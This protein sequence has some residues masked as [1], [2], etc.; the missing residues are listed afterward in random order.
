MYAPP[1]VELPNTSQMVGMRMLR[2]ARHLAKAAAARDEDLALDRQIGAGLFDQ[3]DR[4]QAVREGDVG[5][6]FDS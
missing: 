4:R 3:A 2:A 1:A 6:R 5:K